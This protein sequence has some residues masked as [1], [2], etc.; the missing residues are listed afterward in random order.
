M[1]SHTLNFPLVCNS[2]VEAF[3]LLF[4]A[5][6]PPWKARHLSFQENLWAGILPFSQLLSTEGQL[7]LVALLFAMLEL[8]IG[9]YRKHLLWFV[10]VHVLME[11]G[12]LA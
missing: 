3:S 8:F 2:F 5:N 9:G 1:R 7:G 11:H 4:Q 12:M 10:P 6:F